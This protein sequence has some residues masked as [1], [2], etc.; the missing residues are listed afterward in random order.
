MSRRRPRQCTQAPKQ[1]RGRA[2][3][4]NTA[5][6][7]TDEEPYQKLVNVKNRLKS[8]DPLPHLS[9]GSSCRLLLTFL[10]VF[11]AL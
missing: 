4:L 2:M 3:S 8:V 11:A 5:F 6:P 7:Q 10:S 1:V 9:R